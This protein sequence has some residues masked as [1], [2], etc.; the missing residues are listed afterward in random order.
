MYLDNLFSPFAD[1]VGVLQALLQRERWEQ[2]EGMPD[3][4]LCLDLRTG[5]PSHYSTREELVYEGAIMYAY[6]PEF[7]RYPFTGH[8]LATIAVATPHNQPLGVFRLSLDCALDDRLINCYSTQVHADY[9]AKIEPSEE[10]RWWE[11]VADIQCHLRAFAAAYQSCAPRFTFPDGTYK[12][13]LRRI[14]TQRSPQPPAQLPA[15]QESPA[16]AQPESVVSAVPRSNIDK[17]PDSAHFAFPREKREAI[18]AHF[19]IDHRRGLSI[20]REDWARQKYRISWRTLKAY[21]REF[22]EDNAPFSE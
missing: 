12:S 8:T 20:R 18:A 4:S 2:A 3:G 22:P 11:M 6:R 14:P 13:C 21:L 15:P 10:P 9:I 19:R 5:E 16:A 1:T 7:P 17:S